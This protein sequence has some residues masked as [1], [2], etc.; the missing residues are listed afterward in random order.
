ML[1]VYC[2]SDIENDSFHCD[3]CGKE[4]FLCPNCNL[5]RKGKHCVED[6][7]KL[8][9]PKQKLNANITTSQPISINPA[10]QN[11]SILKNTS[12]PVIPSNNETPILK[13]ENAHLKIDIEIKDGDIIGLSNGR[14][15]NIFSK[16]DQISGTHAK[17]LYD[18]SEG[19]MVIDIGSTGT[20]STNG[21][22]ISNTPNWQSIPKISPNTPTSLKNNSLL[23]IANIEFHVKIILSQGV[24]PTGTKRL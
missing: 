18:L 19:W 6:N 22:R 24:S 7:G 11:N 14:F 16:F 21:T 3:Q 10:P 2:N 12:Q 13:I 4:I 5:P 17:F 8:Y 15:A 9:S 23:L 20:G 1:C